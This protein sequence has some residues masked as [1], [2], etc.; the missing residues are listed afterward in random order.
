MRVGLQIPSFT[1]PGGAADFPGASPANREGIE[2]DA[3]RAALNAR[4][5][6]DRARARH[7]REAIALSLHF[8]GL[9]VTRCP[10]CDATV[11]EE[12]VAHERV[13]HVCCLC[14]RPCAAHQDEGRVGGAGEA[15]G[16][17]QRLFGQP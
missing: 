11:N 5:I 10:N 13:T 15:P 12:A 3:E 9:E 17:R 2:L 14:S 8:T 16:L 7:L 4:I 6:R 1:W